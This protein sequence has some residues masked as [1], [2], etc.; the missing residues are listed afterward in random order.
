MHFI[1]VFGL[2]KAAR[3]FSSE[4]EPSALLSGAMKYLFW[5]GMMHLLKNLPHP[6]LPKR[7]QLFLSLVSRAFM[8]YFSYE[9]F[10]PAQRKL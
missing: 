1:F 5:T 6:S 3:D 9:R 4:I 10:S 2:L 8:Q 7:A